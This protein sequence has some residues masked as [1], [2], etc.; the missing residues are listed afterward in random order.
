VTPAAAQVANPATASS[1]PEPPLR[2]LSELPLDLQR[3]VPALSFGGSVYS[4]LPA[5][6]M[7]ILNG[8]VLREGDAVS[9]EIRLE[10]I[11]PHSAV[12]RLR[13]QRFE[14]PF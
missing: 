10:E 6:R 1:A 7:V 5:Q 14:M 13:G 3:A 12:M 8:Q 4:E 11:R 9:D 2:T